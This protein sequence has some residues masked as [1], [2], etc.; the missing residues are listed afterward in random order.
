MKGLSTRLEVILL[1]KS[2]FPVQPVAR[3]QLVG[4]GGSPPPNFSLFPVKKKVA[5]LPSPSLCRG[6]HG[7]IMHIKLVS[8]VYKAVLVPRYNM[9]LV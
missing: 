6:V 4:K 8:E 9:M 7:Y 2:M 1:K 3:K 5:R